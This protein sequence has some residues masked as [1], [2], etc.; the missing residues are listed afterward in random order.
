[1]LRE[2]V[3]RAIMRLALQAMYTA[4]AGREPAWHLTKAQR[5]LSPHLAWN[6]NGH[7]NAF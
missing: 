2:V 1:V 7:E 5:R 6:H 3:K 4:R